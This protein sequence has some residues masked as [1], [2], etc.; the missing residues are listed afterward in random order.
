MGIATIPLR[1]FIKT[2]HHEYVN[3]NM[4]EVKINV[5]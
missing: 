1:G 4:S 3:P 2:I 5:L